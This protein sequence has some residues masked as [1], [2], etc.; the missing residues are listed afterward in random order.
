MI[1]IMHTQFTLKS[2]INVI[3]PNIPTLQKTVNWITH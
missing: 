1:F 3:Q 2:Q